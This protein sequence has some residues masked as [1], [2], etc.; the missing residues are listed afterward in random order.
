M[1]GSASVDVDVAGAVER[2]TSS[3]VYLSR[4]KEDAGTIRRMHANTL[5]HET[6]SALEESLEPDW[7]EDDAT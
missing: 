2:D 7:N 4:F 3:Q 5:T 1:R 6:E